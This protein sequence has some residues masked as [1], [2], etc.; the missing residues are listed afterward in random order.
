M[1]LP[2]KWAGL[3]DEELSDVSGIP[4]CVFLHSG[5]F[6][7]GNKTEKGALAMASQALEIG[8]LIEKSQTEPDA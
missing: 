8:K 1:F 2:E 7:G 3:R 6:I 5:R 4:D